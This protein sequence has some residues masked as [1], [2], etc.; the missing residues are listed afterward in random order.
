MADTASSPVATVPDPGVIY[1]EFPRPDGVLRV[2][3]S[4]Y[5]G[6]PV[7]SIRNWYRSGEGELRPCQRRGCSLRATELKGIVEAL[8]KVDQASRSEAGALVET[9]PDA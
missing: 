5:K 3:V 7:I 8:L 4:N 6:R 9:A 2:A 1:G